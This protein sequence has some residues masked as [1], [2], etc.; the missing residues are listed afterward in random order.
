[1]TPAPRRALLGVEACLQPE[2]HQA[3][4]L[5]GVQGR[6]GGTNPLGLRGGAVE[7]QVERQLGQRLAAGGNPGQHPVQQALD[8]EQQARDV[9]LRIVEVVPRDERLADPQRLQRHPQVARGQSVQALGIRTETPAHSRRGQIQESSHRPDAEL[10]QAV[11]KR[12]VDA[13]PVQRRL[14]RQHPLGGRVPEHRRGRSGRGGRRGPGDGVGAETGEAD[15]DRRPQPGRPERSEDPVRPLAGRRIEV[16]Q[17]GGVQPEHARLVTTR[18]DVGGEPAQPVRERRDLA[19]DLGRRHLGGVQRARQR[20]AGAVAHPGTDAR[21][22]RRLVR[23]EDHPL[24]LVAVDHRHG[25]ALPIGTPSQQELER[26]RRKLSAGHPVHGTTPGRSS[27]D[28]AA[29]P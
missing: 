12:R 1:M 26:E 10:L 7:P 17:A 28:R 3:Q 15:G 6:G 5:G 24:R 19:L 11:A 8:E 13:Q 18:L 21:L 9:G 16:R 25:A 22:L 4:Q 2:A 27:P 23:P 29:C 14:P 20:Q